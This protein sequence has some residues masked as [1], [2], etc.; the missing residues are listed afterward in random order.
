MVDYA[1]T[2]A[3]RRRTLLKHFGDA[4]KGAISPEACCDNCALHT[5][6]PARPAPATPRRPAPAAVEAQASPAKTE[7][8]AAA[9]KALEALSQAERAALIVLDA[10]TKM[11]RPLGKTRLAQFL[12][13]S[14]AEAVA[15]YQ[16][17]PYFG[18]LGELRLSAIEALIEQLLDSEHLEQGG[19]LYPTLHLT[20]QG[21]SA[22]R[23]RAAIT[24]SLNRAPP[25]GPGANTGGL[26]ATLA[27]TAALLK[28][29]LTPEQIGAERGLP[30]S[31][32]YSHLAT[33]IGEG[34][35]DVNGVIPAET[36][37]RVN[38]AI[39]AVG[40]TAYLAP[41]KAKL[42]DYTTYGEIRCVVEA[43]KRQRT[44]SMPEG[45]GQ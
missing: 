20:P 34:Q 13:G 43:W 14:E 25:P 27:A 31:T 28:R 24:V 6:R 15:K 38:A 32:I 21:E 11:G 9:G 26:S 1:Q 16:D 29:G 12:Q 30:E 3:C 45:G 22:L 10:L 18:R 35:A 8:P 41:I 39:E 44:T 36:Q 37:A 5:E 42:N 23:Q 17:R 19:G 7:G 40:S 4:D 2:R 33:L